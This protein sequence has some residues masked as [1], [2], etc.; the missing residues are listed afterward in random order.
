MNTKWK[1]DAQYL[2]ELCGISK[3]LPVWEIQLEDEISLFILGKTF[4]DLG[5]YIKDNMIIH[6]YEI[7]Q[8][9]CEG[10]IK[11]TMFAKRNKISLVRA[12]LDVEII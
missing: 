11:A 3:D 12:L 4:S 2:L 5:T 8:L 10:L 7:D 1:K 9:G 6:V